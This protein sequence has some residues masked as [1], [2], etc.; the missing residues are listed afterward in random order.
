[1][2]KY[3]QGGD[4]RSNDRYKPVPKKEMN[5]LQ[6]IENLAKSSNEGIIKKA[7]NGVV[8]RSTFNKYMRD[9]SE[10]RGQ[11]ELMKEAAEDDFKDDVEMNIHDIVSGRIKPDKNQTIMTMF[12]AKTKMKKRGYIEGKEEIQDTKDDKIEI[13]YTIPVP[14][15]I[16]D[17]EDI[18]HEDIKE[19]KDGK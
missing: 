17:I 5:K 3:D 2:G 7:I 8:S 13:N 11:I 1:M 9:D 18:E 16:D 19:K 10:F 4:V 15:Q 14:K 6:I 12:Y